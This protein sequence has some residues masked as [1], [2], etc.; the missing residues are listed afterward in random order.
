MLRSRCRKS[1]VGLCSAILT[2]ALL[3]TFTVSSAQGAWGPKKNCY[4]NYPEE[5]HHCYALSEWYMQSSS[6]YVLASIVYM[7]TTYMDVPGWES[8]DFVTNESWVKFRGE[9]GW[10]ET[11]QIGGN[12]YDCCSLHAFYAE[13]Y[14]GAFYENE[15]AG[16]VPANTYNHYV[17]FDSEVNGAW[18]VYWG[19]CEVAKLAGWPV[20]A[21]VLEAGFEGGANSQPYNWGRQMVAASD[22][23]AWWSWSGPYAAAK[24]FR[25]PG[26]CI[27]PNVESSA[28]GNVMWGTCEAPS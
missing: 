2:V 13:L 23:G 28:A 8:G 10:I 16:T 20:Y 21:S 11:G 7:D 15:S 12:P 25:S 27:E 17:I 3:V 9:P 6:E 19:C 18:H 14:K 5:N 4:R 1:G 24:N 26:M 22:G